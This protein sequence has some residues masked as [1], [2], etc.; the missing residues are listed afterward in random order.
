M[1]DEY[2]SIRATRIGGHAYRYLA[3]RPRIGRVV[4]S[5]SGGLNLLFGSG[6][7]FVPVQSASVPLHPWAIEI[8]GEP[9]RFAEGTPVSAEQRNLSLGNTHV[10]ISDAQIEDLQ[11]PHFSAG[12]VAIAERNFPIL[13]RFVEQARK[14]HPPDP[15]QPQID[16]I[17]E[18]WQTAADPKVLLG[19][20]GVG[21]GSTSSGDDVLVGILAGMHLLED[22]DNQ[23]IEVLRQLRAGIQRIAGTR[24]PLPSAQMLLAS[25]DRTFPEPLLALLKGFAS[26]SISEERILETAESVAQLG[27]YSGLA[28]LTGLTNSIY[29][30][31]A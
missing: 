16:S 12:D 4:S 17:V 10:V 14:T 19:L 18:H 28:M 11:L 13:A 23:T 27:H 29:S 15:F 3:T 8:P 5:F 2:R 26:S 31:K 30:I 9:L 7:A 6:E 21:A 22:V 24:T 25:C 1:S 20:I